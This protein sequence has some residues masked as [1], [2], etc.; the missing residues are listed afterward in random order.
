MKKEIF[1]TNVIFFINK[2]MLNKYYIKL[3]LKYTYF[4]FSLINLLILECIFK[5]LL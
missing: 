4:E 3:I 1:L 5:N 2:N